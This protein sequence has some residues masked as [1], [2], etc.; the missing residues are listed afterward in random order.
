MGSGAYDYIQCHCMFGPVRKTVWKHP[1]YAHN[2][3][4]VTGHFYS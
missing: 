2:V 4:W 3:A 1:G